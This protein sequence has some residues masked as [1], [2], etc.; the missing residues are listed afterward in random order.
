MIQSGRQRTSF[1]KMTR[2]REGSGITVRAELAEM[3]GADTILHGRL[4]DAGPLLLAR[5]P[6]TVPKN[7]N[8]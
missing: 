6:G 3:L 1:M 7:G 5:L 4:G 8:R 2:E